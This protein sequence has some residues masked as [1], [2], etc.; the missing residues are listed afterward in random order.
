M[1]DSSQFHHSGKVSFDGISREP[2]V[3]PARARARRPVD[4]RFVGS[5]GGGVHPAASLVA[6]PSRDRDKSRQPPRIAFRPTPDRMR[7]ASPGGSTRGTHA[8]EPTPDW[9]NT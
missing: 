2:I 7:A 1:N 3:A 9:I 4:R 5:G 8:G 6:H